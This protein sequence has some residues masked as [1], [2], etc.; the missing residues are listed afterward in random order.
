M[1]SLT[2]DRSVLPL[3]HFPLGMCIARH[4]EC[5]SVLVLRY[6]GSTGRRIDVLCLRPDNHCCAG[7]DGPD[8]EIV[9]LE[10][11]VFEHEVVKGSMSLHDLLF[12]APVHA[13]DVDE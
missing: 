3:G 4:D 1:G 5:H 7:R 11:A 2:I 10:V 8:G 13:D 6:D 12:P 9:S